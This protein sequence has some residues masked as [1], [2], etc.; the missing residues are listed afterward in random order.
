MKIIVLYLLFIKTYINFAFKTENTS[1]NT[2]GSTLNSLLKSNNNG[3]IRRIKLNFEND[4]NYKKD[5]LNNNINQI[6]KNTNLI[7]R[8]DK[9]EKIEDKK[10]KLNSNKNEKLYSLPN[11]NLVNNI[12][13]YMFVKS[14][15]S[16]GDINGKN[17]SFKGS[18]NYNSENSNSIIFEVDNNL[19]QEKFIVFKPPEFSDNNSNQKLNSNFS[20]DNISV[21]FFDLRMISMNFIPKI[22]RENN[23][24]NHIYKDLNNFSRILQ[25]ELEFHFDRMYSAISPN[26]SLVKEKLILSQIFVP[27]CSQSTFEID[28][29]LQPFIKFIEHEFNAKNENLKMNQNKRKKFQAEYD[30]EEDDEF[31]HYKNDSNDNKK[32][33]NN[34]SSKDNLD[35]NNILKLLNISDDDNMNTSPFIYFNTETLDSL[36]H[37]ISYEIP[38]S[39]GLDISETLNSYMIQNNAYAK[40]NGYSNSNKPINIPVE[41]VFSSIKSNNV[42]SE[43]DA[44]N[45]NYILYHNSKRTSSVPLQS[46]KIYNIFKNL[47]E[48]DNNVKS[49]NKFLSLFYKN[50]TSIKNIENSHLLKNTYSNNIIPSY[51]DLFLNNQYESIKKP[52]NET[53]QT[54]YNNNYFKFLDQ[55]LSEKIKEQQLIQ[56]QQSKKQKNNSEIKSNLNKDKDSNN[57]Y[58]DEEK[59]IQKNEFKKIE[60]SKSQQKNLFL[61][62]KNNFIQHF[63]NEIPYKKGKKI[64]FHKF[65]KILNDKMIIFNN[66]IKAINKI[67]SSNFTSLWKMEN[68]KV[69]NIY[70][71][72]LYSFISNYLKNTFRKNFKKLL[73]DYPIDS[74]LISFVYNS[75]FS[76]FDDDISKIKLSFIKDVF[77]SKGMN[78]K[79]NYNNTF[80]EEL[81][82]YIVF[83]KSDVGGYK[84]INN[85]KTKEKEN[86]KNLNYSNSYLDLSIATTNNT[87]D[88][89]ISNY[90]SFITN[91]TVTVDK[92]EKKEL[93]DPNLFST[94]SK[95]NLFYNNFEIIDQI[96]KVDNNKSPILFSANFIKSILSNITA[97]FLSDKESISSIK[98]YFENNEK[99][100]FENFVKKRF[101][102]FVKDN[103]ISLFSFTIDNNINKYQ[104]LNESIS[105][106]NLKIYDNSNYYKDQYINE[107]NMNDIYKSKINNTYFNDSYISEFIVKISKT[108][109]KNIVNIAFKSNI[110]L[111]NLISLNNPKI[112]ENHASYSKFKTKNLVNNFFNKDLNTFTGNKDF[113]KNEDGF[114]NYP[115]LDYNVFNSTEMKTFNSNSKGLFYMSNVMDEDIISASLVSS[116][117]NDNLHLKLKPNEQT[118]FDKLNLID[119]R[120]YFKGFHRFLQKLCHDRKL[121]CQQIDKKDKKL[122]LQNFDNLNSN[123]INSFNILLRNFLNQ[124]VKSSKEKEVMQ[125]MS[126][127]NSILLKDSELGNPIYNIKANIFIKDN[128]N[129]KL[130]K[131]NS[132]PKIFD[133]ELKNTN[134]NLKINKEKNAFLDKTNFFPINY[135]FDFDISNKTL[136]TNQINSNNEKNN[137]TKRKSLVRL[138]YDKE[139]YLNKPKSNNI[140]IDKIM[141][142]EKNFII[143][144]FSDEIKMLELDSKYGSKGDKNIDLLKSDFDSISCLI[145]DLIDRFY[146][147][148]NG[149]VE[150]NFKKET[151][152]I[153]KIKTKTFVKNAFK[154]TILSPNYNN[155]ELYENNLSINKL[156]GNNK[157]VKSFFNLNLNKTGEIKDLKTNLFIESKHNF[158]LSDNFNLTITNRLLN[159]NKSHKLLN[160][161]KKEY[162][163]SMSN[164]NNAKNEKISNLD[165]FD[166]I[167]QK[168]NKLSSKSRLTSIESPTEL[169]IETTSNS[170]VIENTLDNNN[171]N[172][173]THDTVEIKEINDGSHKKKHHK[174]GNKSFF[175]KFVLNIALY[176]FSCFVLAILFYLIFYKMYNISLAF[177]RKNNYKQNFENKFKILICMILSSLTIFI[178]NIAIQN[179][180]F[181]NILYCID[182]L[183]ISGIFIFSPRRISFSFSEI[184]LCLFGILIDLNFIIFESIEIPLKIFLSIVIVIALILVGYLLS[185]F[186][187]ISYEEEMKFD[188]SRI[189][190]SNEL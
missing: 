100:D 2:L 35:I 147:Q 166:V 150:N 13:E 94:S 132:F 30:D 8:Q 62:S 10:G 188:E 23:Y 162:S 68:Q 59:Q 83:L 113:L 31:S 25:F 49:I 104:L 143:S 182:S 136:I 50:S 174:V 169:Q 151:K 6:I 190:K 14:F 37:Y 156:T 176:Y 67:D 27:N 179:Y 47:N 110:N 22:K 81:Y 45:D 38:Y 18:F 128:Y 148:A 66:E 108:V 109:Y 7:A 158:S 138:N 180:L 141:E 97:S 11:S 157:E 187:Y 21:K 56:E 87:I 79:N 133:K 129:D 9:I 185:I 55:I 153:S 124:N 114:F 117:L 86:I 20:K 125:I 29:L 26:N 139:E 73:V 28:N 1:A 144:N 44:L 53:Y 88:E 171:Q 122:E 167:K 111:L 107:E 77:D 34:H 39:V 76:Y 134:L 123:D 15:I 57:D 24:F 4:M 95:N 63:S 116:M 70:E 140:N 17:K 36:T 43:Y 152:E 184:G 46:L 102:E 90:S 16:D 126:L 149:I 160:E 189:N 155:K 119:L 130:I 101:L 115:E 65:S 82:Y 177:L 135:K 93:L 3:I 181:L 85:I 91:S 51:C 178:G 99:S 121:V 84:S 71:N 80:F 163:Q 127:F 103:N 72:G 146:E 118:F 112:F 98:S 48:N 40:I 41:K 137:S 19:N 32:K 159:L 5:S 58:K 61:K 165:N 183:L 92:I 142:S 161:S 131:S 52:N 12:D 172:P 120:F 33:N 106:E 175:E 60:N 75:S 64:N 186:R 96:I 54:I 69:K 168:E 78:Y 74:E 173:S 89:N 164:G 42:T 105:D 154:T 170:N 145:I